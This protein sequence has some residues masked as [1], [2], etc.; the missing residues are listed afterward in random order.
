[1]ANL[2]IGHVEIGEARIWIR[3]DAKR[4]FAFISCQSA[5]GGAAQDKVKQL[6]ARHDFT[7]VVEFSGLSAGTDYTVNVSFGAE[8]TA[9]P[10]ERTTPKYSSG[11][12]TTAP[13]NGQPQRISF[14]LGSCNLHSLGIVSSPDKAFKR[15]SA[16]VE[17][18]RPDF[19]IHCGDQIYY[20]IPIP[21]KLPDL[22]EYRDKYKDAWEDCE[23]AAKLLT[24]CPHYMILDDHEI[25]NNFHNDM[26]VNV[27]SVDYLK[28]ISLK[29]YREYQHIHNPQSFGNQALYF[30]FE[31]A[32]CRF[33]VLDSRTERFEKEPDN[34]MIGE[35]QMAHF[36]DWLNNA[37]AHQVN[38]V[39]TSVPFVGQVRKGD[40][41]WCGKSYNHQREEI[42]D[43][44]VASGT[45][46]ICFLTGDMHNS[47]YA[48]MAVNAGAANTVTIHEIMASPINQLSKSS[49]S[50]YRQNHS[51]TTETDGN[52]YEV[53][54]SDQHF[55][56]D[57]SNIGHISVD[58]HQITFDVYRTKK[59]KAP[60]TLGSF[61]I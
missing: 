20:D 60:K 32:H 34:Q 42:I 14:L 56:D 59:T 7:G 50:R 17:E 55:Y 22:D 26:H 44:I 36:K 11:T 33:F 49:L 25:R 3:G 39:V 6:E 28:S 5:S 51:G 30:T 40:D 48:S 52:S 37:Q 47:Y 29:A 8:E 38:F 2:I 24:Q 43:A 10:S 23:P 57:H 45:Q 1:M 15:I 35:Q 16:L 13:Q 41:K 53:T 9:P 4:P 31:R 54:L 21:A 58:G 12:F 27:G 19:M 61:S 18:K 46:R